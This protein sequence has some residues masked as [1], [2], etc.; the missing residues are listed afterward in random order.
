MVSDL[1][2]S[3][4]AGLG[5]HGRT[6]DAPRPV[7]CIPDWGII[8]RFRYKNRQAPCDRPV[9]IKEKSA[10]ESI[11][12][13]SLTIVPAVP[14][15]TARAHWIKRTAREFAA[16]RDLRRSRFQNA[17]RT[18]QATLSRTDRLGLESR[19]QY[20]LT[21]WARSR[22]SPSCTS[23][24]ATLRALRIFRVCS[25]D[26]PQPNPMGRSDSEALALLRGAGRSNASAS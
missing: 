23:G 22:A 18:G 5:G 24:I 10:R 8:E 3:V 6:R 17:P 12:A 13:G 7:S 25:D 1:Q 19:S 9:L 16:L 2:M 14:V 15:R 26:S 21:C 20:P 11:D 4:V